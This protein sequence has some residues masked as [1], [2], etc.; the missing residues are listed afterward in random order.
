MGFRRLRRRRVCPRLAEPRS[1]LQPHTLKNLHLSRFYTKHPTC[2]QHLSNQ[3][4]PLLL[5]QMPMSHASPMSHLSYFQ[6]FNFHKPHKH[7]HFHSVPHPC[8]S[9][10]HPYNKQNQS[11]Q[12]KDNQTIELT[13]QTRSVPHPCHSLL[14][15]VTGQPMLL[16][17]RYYR[18]SDLPYHY[19][20]VPHPCRS[21]LHPHNKQNKTR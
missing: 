12:R 1:R 9:L 11:R 18:H 4:P 13:Y 15:P 5:L 3:H 21:L 8:R 20:S 7:L 19:R 6:H 10:L 14:H 16:K 17:Q 2:N